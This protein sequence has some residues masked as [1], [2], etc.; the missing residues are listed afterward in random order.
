MDILTASKPHHAHFSHDTLTQAAI[1]AK[2]VELH[3]HV[4]EELPDYIMVL[5]ANRRSPSQ[6]VC[7]QLTLLSWFDLLLFSQNLTPQNLWLVENFSFHSL[8]SGV[9]P[10]P[11]PRG[12]DPAVRHLALARTQET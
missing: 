4:D 3:V 2:L 8:P 9:G 7:P 6:M 12:A 10:E 11:V 1:K 5:V